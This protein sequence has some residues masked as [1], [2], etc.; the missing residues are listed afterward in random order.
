MYWNRLKSCFPYLWIYRREIALGLLSLALTDLIG[1]AIP[2]LLKTVIDLLPHKPSGAELLRYSLLILLV[3]GFMMLFRF[4]WRRFLFG[5][6]RKIEFDILNRL[7]RRFQEMDR[8]YYQFQHVGELMSRATNDLRAVRDFMGMG[9]LVVVDCALVTSTAL[10]LMFWINHRLALVCLMPLPVVSLLFYKFTAEIAKR[11]QIVQEH[12]AKISSMVQEN[13]AGIRVLHA[14]VQEEVEKSKF[15][16]LNREYVRKNIDLARLFGIFNPALTVTLGVS[17]LISLW[18]GGKSVIDGEMSLGTFV[19]FNG[20]LLMLSWPM[21]GIGYIFT[22]TQRGLSAMG[23]INEILDA[24][25]AVQDRPAIWPTTPLRGEIIF[26]GLTFRYPGS[27]TDCLHGVDC[28][29]EAG[30]C[31]AIIGRIGAGKSTLVQLVPRLFDVG[32]GTVLIDGVP[33]E[34]YPLSFLRR[35]IG[36]VGQES[37]L[38]STTLRENIAFG[39]ESASEQEILEVVRFAGLEP[40][41]ERFPLGLDTLVG[42]RGISLSGGQKQRV[43]LARALIRKPEI[44]ILDD[45][46]SSLDVETEEQVLGNIRTYIRGITT[47]IVSHRLS[48]VQSANQVIVLEK[49]VVVDCGPHADLIARDG[50]YRN[51]YQDQRLAREMDLLIQ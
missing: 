38:F 11:Q 14:F 13:A 43:S 5:P 37:F 45:A 20:Y 36:Y 12:L 10:A 30:S 47:L 35:S 29:I 16:E 40:D 23:R 9:L 44:L 49:G 2:W 50:Y 42:E 15:A 46:F 48:A 39:M 22:L 4:G 3:A 24:R 41:L 27:E 18:M 21:M 8:G 25:P 33:V 7:M 1:L 51:V 28:T 19:A 6:S 17:G 34:D 31:T 32:R 26:R